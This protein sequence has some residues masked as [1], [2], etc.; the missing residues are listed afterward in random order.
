MKSIDYKFLCIIFLLLAAVREDFKSYKIPN[1]LI[2]T[3]ITASFVLHMAE[4]GF[5]SILFWVPGILLP[6]LLLFPLFVIRVVGAGDIKLFCVIGSFYGAEFAIRTILSSFLAAAVFSI[7]YIIRKKQIQK[8]F[9]VLKNY[10]LKL[11]LAKNMREKEPH[12][13][14]YYDRNT[15]KGEGIIHF[16]VSIL[17]GFVAVD[18]LAVYFPGIYYFS[19]F[20]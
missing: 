19:T 8:R 14:H 15:D 11:Y 18:I 20:L 12:W 6:F 3:G 7:I 16:S 13:Y 5:L 9:L 17:T 10:I 1:Y 2:V 4:H